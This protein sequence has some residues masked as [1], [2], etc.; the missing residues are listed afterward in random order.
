MSEILLFKIMKSKYC[1]L[2]FFLSLIL[3]YFLVPK[4]MFYG[5]YFVLATI[6]IF[7][8]SMTMVCLVRS[9][10]EKALVLKRQGVGFFSIVVSIIGLGAMQF[11]SV[12]AP[13]CGA[14]LGAGFLSIIFPSFMIKF[15]ERYSFYILVFSIIVQALILYQ[16]GCFKNP[17]KLSQKP[18]KFS[19]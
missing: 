16:V 8:F 19:Y 6:Y 7:L 13:M 3:G 15:F 14:A 11:C 4:R 5:Y 18:K 2:L 12:G 17:K 9:I 10:K 1:I